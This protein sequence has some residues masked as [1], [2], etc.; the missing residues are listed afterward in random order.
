[1]FPVLALSRMIACVQQV[2]QGKHTKHTKQ[3]GR[4]P[5]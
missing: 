4:R 1:M 5:Q 3:K 2:M